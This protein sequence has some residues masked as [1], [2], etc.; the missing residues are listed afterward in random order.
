MKRVRRGHHEQPAGGGAGD[1]ERGLHRL[2]T[3]VAEERVG[4]VA[5]RQLHETL[6][7]LARGGQ[8]RGLDEARLRVLSDR[9]DCLPDLR[10]VVPERQRPI[11]SG[12]VQIGQPGRV[13]EPGT[14]PPH[15]RDVQ[16]EPMQQAGQPRVDVALVRIGYRPGDGTGGIGSVG[17]GSGGP[18]GTGGLGK[19]VDGFGIS[20]I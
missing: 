2:G 16:P 10:R 6:G 8:R 3:A 9:L 15:E 4:E 12:E 7:Q 18:G 13:I 14:L 11:G 1:L 5:G 20:D 17:G 19:G